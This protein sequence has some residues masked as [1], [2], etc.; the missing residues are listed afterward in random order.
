MTLKYPLDKYTIERFLPHRD[1]M[2]FIDRVIY[3]DETSIVA[4]SDIKAEAAYFK[5]HFPDLPILPGVM[6]IE[7]VAQAGALIVS[8]SKGL[9]AGS[10]I[11]F[12]GVEQAKFR[13]PVYPGETLLI[14]AKIERSRR[15]FYKFSGEAFVGESLAAQLQFSATQMTFNAEA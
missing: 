11:A 14:K 15:G 9:E 2:L 4:E 10:F 7:T 6:I 5:G 12:S 8:L 3:A 13:K 1:P